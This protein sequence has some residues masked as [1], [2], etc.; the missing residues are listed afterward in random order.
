MP[1]QEWKEIGKLSVS[2]DVNMSS[3]AKTKDR[4]SKRDSGVSQTARIIVS[5]LILTACIGGN[6][7]ALV[8][9]KS[10]DGD[11]P[12]EL[13]FYRPEWKPAE[14]LVTVESLRVHYIE[15]GT[16]RAV[17][18]I[19][20]NAGAVEDFEFGAVQLLSS[21]YRVFA[22]DRPGHG[23]SD[24]PP[25]KTATV[26]SQAR[27]LHQTLS[28]LGIVQPVLVG[29]SWGAALALAYVL[30]YPQEVSAMVL[31]APAAYPDDGGNSLL[32][33]TIRIPVVGDLGLLLGK[34]IMGRRIL[35]RFLARAFYPQ[36]VPDNYFKLASSSWLGRRKLKAYVEDESALND[37]LKKMSKRYS[38]IRIPVVI[39]TG[40][41][42]KIVSPKQNAYRL[43]A[44][45][46][47]S[48]LIELK[49]TGHE[50]PQTRPESISVALTLISQSTLGKLN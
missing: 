19:H 3:V 30:E 8:A 2:D 5:V 14:H 9:Q 36:S 6:D 28:D 40:D 10:D 39:V 46:H 13:A 31:L 27:L 45:I 50:I 25:G 16:G 48:R 26:E 44:A 24:R 41:E 18:M 47:Q 32:R 12:K 34:S 42:D 29:H 1:L 21:D 7:L 15:S 43:Q 11:V 49:D 35:K 4:R 33:K 23:R 20:G 38:E 22:I 17:V 37:S